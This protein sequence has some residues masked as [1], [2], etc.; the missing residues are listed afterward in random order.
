MRHV[1]S[2][3]NRSETTEDQ[4]VIVHFAN[5][6]DSIA[7]PSTLAALRTAS[8]DVSRE[9]RQIRVAITDPRS[10]GFTVTS[11][12]SAEAQVLKRAAGF[13][14]PRSDE[15]ALLVVLHRRMNAAH[16]AGIPSYAGAAPKHAADRIGD[17]GRVLRVN[18]T[19]RS[20]RRLARDLGSAASGL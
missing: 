3:C 12:M 2:I 17:R 18:V 11:D 19:Q 8:T 7:S 4:N 20:E 6:G 1:E 5:P 14:Q 9:D 10:S 16:T 13:S 15:A